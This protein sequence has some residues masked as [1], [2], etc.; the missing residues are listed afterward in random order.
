MIIGNIGKV[1]F[2]NKIIEY[3]VI[4]SKI[5]NLYIQIK[6]NAVT[7]KAPI[8]MKDDKIEKFINQKSKWIYSSLEKLKEKN[9]EKEK[10]KIDYTKISN[11]DIVKLNSNIRKYIEKYSEKIGYQPNKVTIKDMKSAWGSCTS[12]KNI[13]INIKLAM[14]DEKLLEY[15]VIHELCHLKYMNHSKNFWDLV[16]QNMSD[17]LVYRKILKEKC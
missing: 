2:N 15:V 10:N 13:S 8:K 7:V 16:E 17:Y 4:R 12:N 11:E 1:E 14:L 9:I 6:E 5:K 3:T